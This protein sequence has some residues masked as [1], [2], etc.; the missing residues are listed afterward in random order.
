MTIGRELWL[1]LWS[2][3]LPIVL[4]IL[5]LFLV[6]TDATTTNTLMMVA[7]G[8]LAGLIV[9]FGFGLRDRRILIPPLAT[10]L[11][12]LG[13]YPLETAWSVDN[14]TITYALVWLGQAIALFV[15]TWLLSRGVAN[16]PEADGTQESLES[17][18]V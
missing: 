16:P 5:L 13:L 11:I 9:G 17:R 6:W 3:I 12:G 1:A 8:A 14:A 10:G 15:S 2:L 4:S 18:L 7:A